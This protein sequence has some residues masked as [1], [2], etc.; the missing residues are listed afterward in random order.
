MN[1]NN[2]TIV[3]GGSSGWIAAAFLKK[4][5]PKKEITVI[6]SPTIPII[7]VG[8]STLADFSNLRDYLGIDEKDFMK[9]TNA[10]Y[11][12]S[13]KFT[14]FYEKNEGSYHYPFRIPD[15]VGTS[16]GIYDWLDIKTI[17]DDIPVDDFV[18][19]YFPHAALFE[20]NKFSDNLS[21]EFGVFNPKTDVG[22]HFDATLFGQWLK[23]DYCIPRGVNIINADVVSVN[24]SDQGVDSLTLS[25]GVDI[26]SDLFIDCT[27]FSSLLLGQGLKEEFDSFSHILPNNRAIA[28]QIPYKDKEKELQPFTN[29]TAIENG[30][31]W[32]VPLWSRLG[33]GYVYSDNHATFEEAKL[34]FTQYL[35]S[36][37]M[38]IP[39]TDDDLKDITFRD[40][41]MKTGIYKRTWVKN[42]VAIG[43]SA[44]FIEPLESNALFTVY[45]FLRRLSKSLLRDKVSQWDRDVYNAATRG[46]YNN[47]AEFVALHYTLSN[48][49]DTKY[50]RD[51]SEKEYCNNLVNLIP[52]HNV[53][54]FDLHSRKMF[55]KPRIDPTA[56]I[57]YISV[58]MHYF[59]KDR[60]DQAW[61]IHQ[62]YDN[63][64]RYVDILKENFDKK[65]KKWNKA[66]EKCLSLHEY[67]K[68][69]IY[70]KD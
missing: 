40:I 37:K 42:V 51:I 10:S 24:V 19:C 15:L 55:N 25:T 4:T 59:L 17:Y 49:R 38:V 53:G 18:R 57:T 28:A 66:A 2:I 20:N 69:N 22:Y 13:I 5:F 70:S 29:C 47:F 46:L 7:G 30:W 14:D 36:D 62:D 50:W 32:N 41:S 27:G 9:K 52:T 16:D 8:E 48:R 31:C 23:N 56:G 12:M 45:W 1:I 67:L 21:G 63:V 34:E 39:R 44:G 61:E 11:K 60:I 3:G 65:K 33:T 26:T 68:Q 54:F 64:K 35:K 43:L 6:E 58:G